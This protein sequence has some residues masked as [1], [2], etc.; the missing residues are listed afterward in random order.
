LKGYSHD[1]FTQKGRAGKQLCLTE[2]GQKGS[3]SE[4]KITTD[5]KRKITYSKLRVLMQKGVMR[6]M[7]VM[8]S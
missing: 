7:A 5:K 1:I 6:S 3:L 2:K 4:K 8:T